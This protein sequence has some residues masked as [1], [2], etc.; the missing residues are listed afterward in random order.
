MKDP[1]VAYIQ[2]CLS[3]MGF[4]PG[5]VD[6]LAGQKTLSALD[7]ALDDP[8][9][10]QALG[11]PWGARVSAAFRERLYA[12]CER[13][14]LVPAYLMACIAWESG[15]TFSPGVLNK[16]GSG[17]TGLIQFMPD[18]AR[19]LGTTTTALA[20]MSAEDQLVWVEKYFS[21]YRGRLESLAD[22]YMAILW[23]AGIGK[24]QNWPLW[25]KGNRPTTY[26]QNA[27]LDTDKNGTI[28]KAEAT[29]KI[30]DKLFKGFGVEHIFY[31][32]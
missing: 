12:L 32:R 14:L 31:P 13:Q 6:G 25:E 28:T 21:P 2:A 19:G 24:P 4:Q 5:P 23:P 16:A 20:A 3:G 8:K 22:H 29:G 27:G 30:V 26:R 7:A 1:N 10:A 9:S 18:T 11:L 15:E 17:A